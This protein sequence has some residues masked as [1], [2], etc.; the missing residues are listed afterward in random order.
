VQRFNVFRTS[1]LHQSIDTPFTGADVIRFFDSIISIIKPR[2]RDNPAP[3]HTVVIRGFGIIDSYG[4][5]QYSKKSGYELTAQDRSHM[6]TWLDGAV[7]AG[8]LTKGRCQEHVW[9]GFTIVSRMGNAWFDHH[10]RHGT[11]SWDVTI[12]KLMSIVLI[13]SLGSRA[14]DVARS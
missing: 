4:T 6:Q 12:A 10:H 14:G 11:W 3:S 7:K 2:A 13:A 9:L 8:R 1:T 5:F